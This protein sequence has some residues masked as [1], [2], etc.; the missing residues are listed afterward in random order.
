MNLIALESRLIRICLNA[1]L[2][3][4]MSGRSAGSAHDEIDARPRAPCSASRSQQLPITGA[5]ANGSGVISKLPVSIFDMSRMPLTTDSRWWPESLI[6]VRVF[7]RGA[8]RR[9]AS[10]SSFVSISEKP[11]MALSGVRSSW[12]MVARKRLLAALAR[13]A[14]A[15]ASSSAC[16]CTLRSVTSRITAT[17]SRSAASSSAGAIERPAAHLDPDEL[18]RRIGRRRRRF[19]AD[20]EFDR[21]APRP[22]RRHRQ[23]R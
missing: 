12:L 14:S 2:S 11:M 16:S 8:R 17:T 10:R 7:V 22:A 18:R 20:A 23:A 15:R 9:A 6:S 19:A 3:A 5:G 21:A 4:T 1:R 13:S